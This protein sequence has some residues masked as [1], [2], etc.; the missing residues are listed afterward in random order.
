MYTHS[1]SSN[2]IGNQCGCLCTSGTEHIQDQTT[3]SNLDTSFILNQSDDLFEGET[4]Y[5]QVEE[6]D[7]DYLFTSSQENCSTDTDPEDL[8]APGNTEKK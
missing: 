2:Y 7:D 3:S 8:N 4:P 1:N 6:Q 5:D